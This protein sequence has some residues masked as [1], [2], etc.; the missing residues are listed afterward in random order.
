MLH[1]KFIDL[2]EM[3]TDEIVFCALP[4]PGCP[5]DERIMMSV[6]NHRDVPCVVGLSAGVGELEASQIQVGLGTEPPAGSRSH[7]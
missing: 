1:G 6:S 4:T 2:T 7:W 3:G 5:C